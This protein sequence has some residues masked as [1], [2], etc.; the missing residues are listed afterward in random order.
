MAEKVAKAGIRR[1]DGFLY[2]I[3]K[4]GDISRAKM[5]RGGKKG[6]RPEKV[7]KLGIN[8]A[9]GYLYFL[10]KKGDVSRAKMVRR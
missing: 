4:Q 8:K 5:A 3:D 7:M 6:G 1:Q 9:K 2:F 10:D